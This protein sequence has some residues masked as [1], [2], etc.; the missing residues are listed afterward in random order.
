MRA[1][2]LALLYSDM[3]VTSDM[4]WIAVENDRIGKRDFIRLACGLGGSLDS[5][6]FYF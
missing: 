2:L 4:I 5:S 1:T 3:L 6:L